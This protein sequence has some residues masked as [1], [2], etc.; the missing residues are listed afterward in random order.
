M[1]NII[2]LRTVNL[3]AAILMLI[4]VRLSQSAQHRIRRSLNRPATPKIPTSESL[5]QDLEDQLGASP[6]EYLRLRLRY[7]HSAFVPS[8]TP[9]V[10]LETHLETIVTS[11]IRRRHARSLWARGSHYGDA[12]GEAGMELLM[13]IISRNWEVGKARKAV[14]MMARSKEA[15]R[16]KER[17]R[18]RQR[19]RLRKIGGSMRTP[20]R[21]PGWRAD[22]GNRENVRMGNSLSVSVPE[23]QASLGK[24]LGSKAAQEGKSKGVGGGNGAAGDTGKRDSGRWSWAWW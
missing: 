19:E 3:S 21:S 10:T 13:G 12:E 5:F 22:I 1:S 11:T 24:V 4:Q 20:K 9:N 23:R 8:P 15:E 7:S 6:R 17:M 18:E 16:E 14:D 2:S